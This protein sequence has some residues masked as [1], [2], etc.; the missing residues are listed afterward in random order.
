MN[1]GRPG[2]S[3]AQH[4]ARRE[5]LDRRST[6]RPEEQPRRHRSPGRS[7]RR[8]P[9]PAARAGRRLRLSL[10][11]RPARPLRIGTR[12]ED[13]QIDRHLAQRHGADTGKRA[14]WPGDHDRGEV[15][16]TKACCSQLLR[17]A[18]ASV[19][20]LAADAPDASAFPPPSNW[21]SPP[22]APAS[23]PFAKA[24]TKWSTY[25]PLRRKFVR[26]IN[27]GR[28][29]KGLSL[30]PD[31]RVCTWRIPG[32]TPYR[33]STPRPSQSCAR[34][35]RGSSRTPRS[36][37]P[38]AA[39]STWPTASA[40][41]FRL[42]TWLRRGSQAPR[43]R[44]AAPAISNA[45]ARWRKHLLHA[46]LSVRPGHSAR[47]PNPKSPSS[48]PR[49]QMVG[50]RDPLPTPPESS[51]SRSSADGRLGIA[52]QLRPKNLIPLAHVEHG[53]VFGNSLSV[54]GAD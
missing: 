5:S 22:T 20:R 53:W 40:T 14:A 18:L 26:R 32:A 39:S 51:T 3:A 15:A 35:P 33:R 21:P 2:I 54:F 36:P 4:V 30:S 8:R 19:Q 9:P 23:S 50:E 44:A 42:S 37:I 46:H 16:V 1:L 41:I 38:P 10:P 13:R 47:R 49:R 11:G 7:G 27:V 6:G 34:C 28:V 29:P 12:L 17:L 45:L 24:P 52:A 48:I 31:G 25:D 43:W